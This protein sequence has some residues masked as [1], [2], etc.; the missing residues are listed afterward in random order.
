MNLTR[1]VQAG[2]LKRPQ[3]FLRIDIPCAGDTFSTDH[4]PAARVWERSPTFLSAC[5]WKGPIFPILRPHLVEYLFIQPFSHPQRLINYRV[6]TALLCVLFCVFLYLFVQ[7]LFR[8][9]NRRWKWQSS[10]SFFPIL[11]HYTPY[12]CLFNN[13]ISPRI[14]WIIKEIMFFRMIYFVAPKKRH[15]TQVGGPRLG[16]EHWD[17]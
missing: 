10:G 7:K 8:V 9:E 6:D 3:C 4:L 15:S 12:I 11:P 5:E 17:Y 13:S 1:A 16:S 14:L 2:A